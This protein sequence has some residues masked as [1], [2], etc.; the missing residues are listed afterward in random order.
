M[1]LIV[2]NYYDKI[3]CE[4]FLDSKTNRIRIRPLAD[5]GFPTNLVVESLK[6]I[7]EAHPVGTKFTTDNILVSKKPNGRIHLRAK[8]Q[9]IYKL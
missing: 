2:G 5:Q 7:R 8:D 6:K 1:G 9:M 3:K 4:S